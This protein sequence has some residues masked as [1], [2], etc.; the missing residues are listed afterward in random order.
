MGIIDARSILEEIGRQRED[1][2]DIVG[3]I[4]WGIAVRLHKEDSSEQARPERAA[5]PTPMNKL[6]GSYQVLQ[7]TQSWFWDYLRGYP[8]AETGVF[9]AE[10]ERSLADATRFP[11]P[12]DL[13]DS[14][15]FPDDFVSAL[16]GLD[17]VEVY[18]PRDRQGR[19]FFDTRS[20]HLTRY[21][22]L[23]EAALYHLH[24]QMTDR[25]L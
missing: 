10:S 15:Q 3:V 25:Y 23:S 22:A 18:A 21:S 2:D 5:E 13:K 6:I 12:S 20:G 8:E 7:P 24:K 9:I 4:E 11:L 17:R 14:L 16:E 19:E 1:C